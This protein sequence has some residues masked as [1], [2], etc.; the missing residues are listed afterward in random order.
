LAKRSRALLLGLAA[1]A[2][3]CL[4]LLGLSV[5]SGSLLS[6]LLVHGNRLVVLS[7]NTSVSR[8]LRLATCAQ[9]LPITCGS[10]LRLRPAPCCLCELMLEWRLPTVSSPSR[11]T[12]LRLPVGSRAL[13]LRLLATPR[14]L[15]KSLT[16]GR[17]HATDATL[18]LCE[19]PA[20]CE[21]LL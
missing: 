8:E 2:A 14:G 7:S 11:Q 16:E 12:L 10:L 21:S 4:P 18:L 15:G 5:S 20:G 6:A 3:Q 13:L 19:S 1:T 9:R 17:Q